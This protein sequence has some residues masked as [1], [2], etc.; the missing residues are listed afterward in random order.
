MDLR[1]V[2]KDSNPAGKGDLKAEKR[3]QIPL[4]KGDVIFG[5]NF[6]DNLTLI[7][8]IVNLSWGFKSKSPSLLFEVKNY[9][10]DCRLSE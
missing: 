4:V 6:N 8:S 3:K 2:S 7:L 1:A 9:L 10:I 5:I